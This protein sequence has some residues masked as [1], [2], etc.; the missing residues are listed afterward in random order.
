M[1]VKNLNRVSLS[2]CNCGSWMAHWLSYGKPSVGFMQRQECAVVMCHN[3]F[4]V[5]GHV[6]KEVLEGQQAQGQVGDASWYVLPLCESCHRAQG[7]TL[8]VDDACGLAPVYARETCGR[9]VEV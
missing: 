6:Q 4:E 7:A 5:G 1:V 8:T 3:P 9:E 2:P